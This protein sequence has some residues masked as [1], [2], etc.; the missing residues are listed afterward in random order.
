MDLSNVGIALLRKGLGIVIIRK[1]RSAD[2]DGVEL[3]YDEIHQ[4]EEAGR[5]TTGWI[6]G[7]YPVRSTAEAALQRGDLFVLEDD[8]EIRGAGIIN[9][10]Q[11][12]VYAD[13]QWKHSAP[14]REVCVLHTL[15]ISPRFSGRGYGRGFVKFYEDYACRYDWMEL[16]IDT[17]ERNLTARRM[18]HGLGY[19]EIGIVPTVFNNIPGVNLVLLE[20]NLSFQNKAVEVRS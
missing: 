9:Q 19:E 11:V 14:D 18:Y 7:V 1:A 20:K 6:K 2:I 5:L 13:A 15:V 16:R 17:N 12:D 10:I 4:A 3:I 8:H